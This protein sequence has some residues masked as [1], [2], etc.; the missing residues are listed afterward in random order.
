MYR[1]RCEGLCN[2]EPKKS[3]NAIFFFKNSLEVRR[4]T[5]IVGF[6]FFNFAVGSSLCLLL[7]FVYGYC[8][9]YCD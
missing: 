3:Q 4:Q 7:E 1:G 9:S 5:D 2:L 6:S 8:F